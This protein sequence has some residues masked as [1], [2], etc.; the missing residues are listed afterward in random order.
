M[1]RVF[2]GALGVDIEVYVDD[3]VVKSEKA[4][5]H[6]EVLERLRLNPEKCSFGVQA[7]KFLGFIL[8]E[9]GIEANPDK[10]Q[11]IISMRSLRVSKKSNN[12]WE[13]SPPFHDLSLGRLKLHNPSSGH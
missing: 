11:A 1:D 6:Y 13:E 2:Q 7:R 12:S 9:R 8:T 5:E 4:D 3:M 10:C